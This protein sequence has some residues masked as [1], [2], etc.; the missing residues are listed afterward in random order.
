[1]PDAARGKKSPASPAGDI[2]LQG[3]IVNTGSNVGR[4]LYTPDNICTASNPTLTGQVYAGENFYSST[5]WTF[6]ADNSVSLDSPFTGSSTS[7]D[8]T[9]A[10]IATI[11]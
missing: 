6:T 11:Y 9:T 3:N 5:G 4:L 2:W 7:N 10:S 8:G 1:V